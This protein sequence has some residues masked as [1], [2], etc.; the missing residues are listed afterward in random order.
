MILKTYRL[1]LRDFLPSDLTAYSAIREHPDFRL[2]L[3]ERDSS[4]E[5]SAEL[6]RQFVEWSL[7][8]PRSRYQLAIELPTDGLIGSCGVRIQSVGGSNASF[9]CELAREHW[10][11]GYGL[12]AGRAL[13]EFAFNELGVTRIYAETLARNPAALALASRLGMRVEMRRDDKVTL[14]VRAWEWESEG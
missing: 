1:L 4:P 13:I 9:G 14:E 3:N 5:R 12:E 7:E 10:G 2:L 6:L 11:R 8:S